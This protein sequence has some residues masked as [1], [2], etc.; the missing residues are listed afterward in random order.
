MYIYIHPFKILINENLL[1][2]RLPEKYWNLKLPH[3]LPPKKQPLPVTALPMLGFMEQTVATQIIK[4]CT[5][6]GNFK[7]KYPFLSP[8][9]SALIFVAY[10]LKGTAEILVFLEVTF[11]YFHF[12]AK[13]LN[14]SNYAMA[15][16][17]KG[18]NM[19][20]SLF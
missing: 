9:K 2:F 3:K 17:T 15:H 7:P 5:A 11:L 19:S 20:A 12:E 6:V 13:T 18:K 1:F 14:I 4:A 8:S 16:I 10:H